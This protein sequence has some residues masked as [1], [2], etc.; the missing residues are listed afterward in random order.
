MSSIGIFFGWWGITRAICKERI[1][2]ACT[3]THCPR[4]V[5][6]GLQK[7]W[8]WL[9]TPFKGQL[10]FILTRPLPTIP[11]FTLRWLI[12][13]SHRRVRA[14]VISVASKSRTR[15]DG[16]RAHVFFNG[17]ELLLL[18][19][20]PHF[21]LWSTHETVGTTSYFHT[22]EIILLH[23]IISLA[24]MNFYLLHLITHLSDD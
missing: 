14:R 6:L 15:S 12:C 9:F 17:G 7:M 10:C 11:C 5:W 18:I 24:S 4:R 2:W 21:C 3:H 22:M 19:E 8:S 13:T 23:L 20:G 16:W 1:S